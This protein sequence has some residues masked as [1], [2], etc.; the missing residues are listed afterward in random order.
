M[1]TMYG[2][3][4]GAD[5]YHADRGNAAWAAADTAAKTAALVRASYAI[6]ARFSDPSKPHFVGTKAG[7]FSQLLAWP[8][9]N[10][11]SVDG[12]AVPS[13]AVPAIVEYAA[14]EGALVELNEPG[15]L[16]PVVVGSER[17]VRERV[18]GA[19][20]VQY[21]T[22]ADAVSAATP[23]VTAIN[24]LLAPVLTWAAPAVLVV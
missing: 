13:D 1:A 2:T 21:D 3:V 12:E 16:S 23:V 18:E 10:A 20:D 15:S 4:E 14:Y 17:V 7:G 8:R 11:V 6:D 9:V 19:V 24:G 22:S 5:T